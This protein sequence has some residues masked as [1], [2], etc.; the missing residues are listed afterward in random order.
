MHNVNKSTA[1]A[2][3]LVTNRFCHHCH[4]FCAF[5]V[6]LIMFQFVTGGGRTCQENAAETRTCNTHACPSTYCAIA[7][8]SGNDTVELTLEGLTEIVT[9]KRI[10]NHNYTVFSHSAEVIHAYSKDD[11]SYDNIIYLNNTSIFIHNVV[12]QSKYCIQRFHFKCR[13]NAPS[14]CYF[15]GFN[16]Q[17]I[18]FTHSDCKGCDAVVNNNIEVDGSAYIEDKLWFPPVGMH[19]RDNDNINEYMNITLDKLICR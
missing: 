5:A 11:Y 16:S 4:K 6:E 10:G 1:N 9:C 3:N 13:A 8:A 18:P 2:K 19:F 14:N 12:L 15:K 7:L 17:M